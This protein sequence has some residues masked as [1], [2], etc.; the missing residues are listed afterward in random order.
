MALPIGDA[1]NPR[2]VPVVTYF[3]IAAN[4]AVYL[5]LTLPLSGERPAPGD[6]QLAEYLQVV[7]RSLGG[8]V[9]I[10]ALAEHVSAYELFVYAH[11]FRPAMPGL[12]ALFMSMFLHAGLLHLAGNMLFLWIYGDNVEHRL[13]APAYLVTYLA[14]GIAATL[15]HWAGAPTSLLP[16]IGASGA[17][18][19]ILGC[20]FV[21]FPR[22]VVRILWLLPP[23]IGQVIEVPARLVLGFYLVADNL[24][25]YLLAQGEGGVAD[26][27]SVV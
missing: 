21:W 3:L 22:N 18:S 5:F 10:G 17:I 12:P 16:V 19:G 11:G 2:G 23:F 14:T 27:K 24:V 20:Y 1:P 4:V 8:R 7:S 15:A 25:P 9:P 13:G 26:R 6:P